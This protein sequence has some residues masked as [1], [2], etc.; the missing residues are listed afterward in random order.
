MVQMSTIVVSSLILV[1]TLCYINFSIF[2]AEESRKQLYDA[3]LKWIA[4]SQRILGMSDQPVTHFR[5]I[6]STVMCRRLV[7]NFLVYFFKGHDVSVATATGET[8]FP[9]CNAFLRTNL[10]AHF[11]FCYVKD[12]PF[13]AHMKYNYQNLEKWK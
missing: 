9:I 2:I 13:P 3:G 7:N 12:F 6:V 4:V 8:P 11:I 5:N 10:T 1:L